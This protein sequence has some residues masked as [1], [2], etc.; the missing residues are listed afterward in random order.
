MSWEP[1]DPDAR[2]FPSDSPS[3]EVE[4]DGVRGGWPILK[5]IIWIWTNRQN[6]GVLWCRYCPDIADADSLPPLFSAESVN[7][8]IS[9]KWVAPRKTND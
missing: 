8:N 4:Q 1:I 9:T 3:D 7:P 6:I 2:G 5:F